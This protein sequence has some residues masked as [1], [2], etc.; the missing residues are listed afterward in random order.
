M[1]PTTACRFGDILLVPFPFTD[2][3]GVRKRPAVVASPTAYN[4]GRRDVVIMAVTSQVHSS[5]L[6]GEVSI[7]DWRKAGLLK[8]SVVKPVFATIERKLVLRVLGA[9]QDTDRKS[10]REA[11][12]VLL[13]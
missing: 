9:L 8:P 13:G 11:L 3:T 2:Q 12:R 1:P 4:Q 10:L 5:S 7:V 6:F